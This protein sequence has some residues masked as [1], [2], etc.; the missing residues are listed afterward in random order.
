MTAGTT[1]STSRGRKPLRGNGIRTSIRTRPTTAV[2]AA[3]ASSTIS[4]IF[5]VDG[6]VVNW[7]STRTSTSRS[8]VVAPPSAVIVVASEWTSGSTPP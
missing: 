4:T 6:L 5:A 2:A 7:S 8:A 3:S 1:M